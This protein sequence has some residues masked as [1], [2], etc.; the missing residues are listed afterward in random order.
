MAQHIRI[1]RHIDAPGNKVIKEYIG[2]VATG[3]N[4]ISI[5]WMEAPPGWAEPPQQP[6]FTEYTVVLS[7]A[8]IVSL[9]NEEI[10]VR[11]GEAIVVHQGE[12]VQYR[13]TEGAEY[14]AI[15]LP[16]FSSQL[17]HR[18]EVNQG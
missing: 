13:T 5:A 18:Q 2:R 17:V 1:P 3:T 7:G 6:E 15:C 8:L 11:K 9:K 16:A 10:V 12:W 4:T 14:I